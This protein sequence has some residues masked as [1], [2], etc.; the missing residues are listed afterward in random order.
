MTTY[1][2]AETMRNH[3]TTFQLRRR[4]NISALPREFRAKDREGFSLGSRSDEAA[5][6]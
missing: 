4:K 2:I 1:E 3:P 6:P 5:T